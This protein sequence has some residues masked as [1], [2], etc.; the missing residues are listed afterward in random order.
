MSA[1][2]GLQRLQHWR[3]ELNSSYLIRPLNPSPTQ[4]PN[5]RL[6]LFHDDGTFNL[7]ALT[8]V[9]SSGTAVFA[10]SPTVP[11]LLATHATTALL[12][13]NT[14]GSAGVSLIRATRNSLGRNDLYLNDGTAE[15]GA[16]AGSNLLIRQYDD[17]GAL[18]RTALTLTR[19]TGEFAFGGPLRLQATTVAALPAAAPGNAGRV[20]YVTD[21]AVAPTYNTAIGAGG[22]AFKTLAL[23]DGAAWVSH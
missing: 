12:A 4:G 23:S 20:V 21:L 1:F 15:V 19:A 10:V 3:A 11:S 5:F 13:L 9:R 14:T 8:V 16:N 18:L 2:C 7:T 17:A 6:D 22:G